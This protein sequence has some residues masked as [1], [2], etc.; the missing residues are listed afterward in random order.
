MAGRPVAPTSSSAAGHAPRDGARNQR[1]QH[2]EPRQDG[3]R[4]ARPL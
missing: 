4:R 3:A 2:L 1:M